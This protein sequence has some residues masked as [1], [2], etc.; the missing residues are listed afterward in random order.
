MCVSVSVML[1]FA[2]RPHWAGEQQQQPSFLFL[3]AENAHPIHLVCEAGLF[4]FQD[5]LSLKILRQNLDRVQRRRKK[6]IRIIIIIIICLN[7]LLLFLLLCVFVLCRVSMRRRRSGQ[8]SPS[9]SSQPDQSVLL[10]THNVHHAPSPL[11]QFPFNQA[12]L[13]NAT[14]VWAMGHFHSSAANTIDGLF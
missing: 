8:S 13:L 2:H 12:T 3:A 6:Y 14:R 5:F 11:V 10:L 4:S 9:S 1:E 7:M